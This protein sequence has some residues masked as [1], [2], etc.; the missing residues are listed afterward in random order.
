MPRKQHIVHLSVADRQTLRRMVQHGH[1]P[2]WVLQR[3]RILLHADTGAAGPCWSDAAVAHA[4]D[5]APRSVARVRAAWCTRGW[6]ALQRTPRAAPTPP[7]L[8]AASAARLVALACSTPPDGAARWSL[9]LLATRAAEAGIVESISHETVRQ[10]LKKT[11]SNRGAP[12][13]L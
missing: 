1:Q 7:K 9:R 3:A 10:T 5:V 4:V 8:D 2:A 12:S 13:A 11:R 6:A